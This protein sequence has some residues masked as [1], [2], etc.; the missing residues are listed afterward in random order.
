MSPVTT[1][2]AMTI[3][4]VCRG[5]MP[6]ALCTPRSCTRSRVSSTT[7]L[8]TPSAATVTSM[9]VSSV[10]SVLMTRM[11]SAVSSSGVIAVALWFFNAAS[12]VAT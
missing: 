7:M 11:N 1:T 6:S 3:E 4:M 2:E 12:S 9:R 8:S 10:A 5:V